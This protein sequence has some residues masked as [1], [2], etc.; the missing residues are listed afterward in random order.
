MEGVP[1]LTSA[2]SRYILDDQGGKKKKK[3]MERPV[4]ST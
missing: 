2:T 1:S 3:K 4:W